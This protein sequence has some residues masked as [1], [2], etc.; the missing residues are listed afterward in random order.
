M[1]KKPPLYPHIPKSQM[2]KKET[3]SRDDVRIELWEERD[4]LH[5]GIQDKVTGDYYAS[6]WDDEARQM[7]EDGFFKRKPNL[8]ESVL[9][10]AEEMGIL[11]KGTSVGEI[12]LSGKMVEVPLVEGKAVVKENLG[13]VKAK[14]YYCDNTRLHSNNEVIQIKTEEEDPKC[15]YC[16]AVMTYGRYWGPLL[17]T[18]L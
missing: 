4:R 18:Q 12:K 3:P 10:Y 16:G 13:E 7:F 11:A 6:W 15:P 9:E 1:P 2:K 8:E 14:Y 17:A 5:I